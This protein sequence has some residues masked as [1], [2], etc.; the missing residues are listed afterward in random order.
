LEKIKLACSQINVIIMASTPDGVGAERA[1]S[2][3]A[4]G[5]LKKPFY[6]ADV[7]AVLERI[8]N[9]RK[10]QPSAGQSAL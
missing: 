10:P 7:D 3:G 5:L 2:A 1:H 9:A 6:P 4:D 8:D